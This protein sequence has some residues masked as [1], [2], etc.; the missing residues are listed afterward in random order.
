MKQII[1]E[2]QGHSK[3]ILFYQQDKQNIDLLISAAEDE[4]IIIWDLQKNSILYQKQCE[5]GIPSAIAINYPFYALSYK[6]D[7]KTRIEN[8][9]EQKDSIILTRNMREVFF[10]EFY[11]DKFIIIGSHDLNISIWDYDKQ[12]IVK[13][14][15]VEPIQDLLLNIYQPEQLIHISYAGIIKF[16]NLVKNKVENSFMVRGAYEIQLSQDKLFKIVTSMGPPSKFVLLNNKNK[17]LR[18]YFQRIPSS[19]LI[20]SKINNDIYFKK[21]NLLCKLDIKTWQETILFNLSPDEYID[22]LRQG[23]LLITKLEKLIRIKV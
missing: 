17:I 21:L 5:N 7:G 12:I 4:K 10:L 16:I 19:N 11:K 1:G 8:A 14:I 2:L 9:K 15:K 3:P 23:E 22:I 20:F 6:K 13:A 18:I